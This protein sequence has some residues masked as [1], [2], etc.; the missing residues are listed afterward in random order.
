MRSRLGSLLRRKMNISR[1]DGSSW[2]THHMRSHRSLAAS[3]REFA[4]GRFDKP[5]YKISLIVCLNSF[6]VEIGP[7]VRRPGTAFAGATFQGKPGR[8]ISWAFEQINPVTIEFTDGNICFRSGTRWLTNNDSQSVTSI[9]TANPA[10]VTVVGISPATGKRVTFAN[11]GTSCPLLQNRQFLW[12]HTASNMGTIA[13]AL[14]GTP[15]D[16]STLGMGLAATAT[17]SSIQDVATPYIGGAWS[18]L[19]MVQAETTGILLQGSIAPQALVVATPLPTVTDPV[20]SLTTAV[21]DDGPYLDPFTNGVQAVPA[22]TTG[23]IQLTLQFPAYSA[24]VAY[25][26]GDFVTSSSINYESLIDQ[27]INHTPASS[28]TQWLPVGAG[29]AINDGQGFLATD[30]GRLIRLYSEPPQWDAATSYTTAAVVTYNPTGFP[31]QGTYWQALTGSTGAVPGNDLVHWELVQPGAALPS[32]PNFTNP[33]GAAGPAQWTWGKI[34][35]LLN[36][37]PGTISG[38]ANIGN[39]I[40]NGGLAAGF[41]GNTSQNFA[42]S[43]ASFTNINVFVGFGA[44]MS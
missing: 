25:R 16:G 43:P 18:S 32:I 23:L 17:M 10:V 8:V 36:F 35:S 22:S 21:F 30:I 1:C 38:V 3:F 9:S 44:P 31:G 15:I 6:P 37:I 13:D 40:Q 20:F 34:V 12:T 2:P 24:T 41:N 29:A 11:L 42:A 5:D 39:M 26:T 33:L 28:P 4:S 7:W 27:N 19:R 14:T